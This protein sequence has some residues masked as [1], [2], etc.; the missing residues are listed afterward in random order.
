[1]CLFFLR[2][3]VCNIC[4]QSAESLDSVKTV[5]LAEKLNHIFKIVF[6]ISLLILEM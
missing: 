3:L 4:V 1:M 5:N 2:S 6:A